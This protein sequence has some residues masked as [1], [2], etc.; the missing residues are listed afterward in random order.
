MCLCGDKGMGESSLTP[1]GVHDTCARGHPAEHLGTSWSPAGSALHPSPKQ[2]EWPPWLRTAP[3][4][5]AGSPREGPHSPSP[6]L[7]LSHP[8]PLTSLVGVQRRQKITSYLFPISSQE[9]RTCIASAHTGSLCHLFQTA[10][11]VPVSRRRC[12]LLWG[13]S[14]PNWTTEPSP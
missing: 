1:P 2:C 14:A 7:S 8:S 4:C 6:D 11:G 10:R 9:T 5:F 3:G 13:H 12:D